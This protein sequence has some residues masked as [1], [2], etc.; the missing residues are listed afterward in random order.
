MSNFLLSGFRFSFQAESGPGL[1]CTPQDLLNLHIESY[2]H[3]N[4]VSHLVEDLSRGFQVL[5]I[6]VPSSD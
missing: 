4:A 3:S 6:V 1:T 2:K 5:N